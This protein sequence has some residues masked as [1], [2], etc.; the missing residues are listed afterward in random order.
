M[1][2]VHGI[3]VAC[4]AVLLSAGWT[5]PASS[6]GL[7]A[8][9][10]RLGTV[11]PEDGGAS[12]AGGGHLEFEEYGSRFHLTPNVLFWSN[13]GLT[14]INPNF[15]IYYHF[16]R[17]GKVSPYIGAGAA[18]HMYSADGPFDPGSDLGLNLFG[19][20]L[21][22]VGRSRLFAELRYS[23]TDLAQTSFFGGL[24]FPISH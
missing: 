22:P 11:D 19:G 6:F 14:D 24:T 1:K 10:V 16:E 9:G 7:S 12:F 23:A 3:V 13:D 5:A 15:D 18:L 4:L 8:A 21:F 17:T 2:P 20:A